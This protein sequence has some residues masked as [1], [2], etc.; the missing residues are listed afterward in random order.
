VCERKGNKINMKKMKKK[1][2]RE[3]TSH[4]PSLKSSPINMPKKTTTKV[5]LNWLVLQNHLQVS[6][7]LSN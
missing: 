7:L 4:P 2:D 1:Y 6:Y 3:K 5:P